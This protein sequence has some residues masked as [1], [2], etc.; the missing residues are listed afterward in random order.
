MKKKNRL[1]SVVLTAMMLL[2]MVSAGFTTFAAQPQDEPESP[3]PFDVSSLDEIKIYWARSKEWTT[4]ELDGPYGDVDENET[5]LTLRAGQTYELSKLLACVDDETDTTPNYTYA[6]EHYNPANLAVD[7]KENF[8][9]YSSMKIAYADEALK[10]RDTLAAEV[11]TAAA[12]AIWALYDAEKKFDG[13]KYDVK[14]VWD[15]GYRPA[16]VDLL[17]KLTFTDTTVTPSVTYEYDFQQSAYQ[18][19]TTAEF[20]GAYESGAS[21][22]AGDVVKGS[23]GSFYRYIGSGTTTNPPV[24]GSPEGAGAETYNSWEHLAVRIADAGSEPA[25]AYDVRYGIYHYQDEDRFKRWGNAANQGEWCTWLTHTEA[26]YY[27]LRDATTVRRFSGYFYLSDEDYQN[28]DLIYLALADGASLITGDDSMDVF[29]NGE[30]LYRASTN[31]NSEGRGDII[32]NGTNGETFSDA[33]NLLMKKNGYDYNNAPYSSPCN[34]PSGSENC[35]IAPIKYNGGSSWTPSD[36]AEAEKLYNENYAFA[37]YWHVHT[38]ES[39]FD[40]SS[41]LKPGANRIDIIAGDYDDGGGMSRLHLFTTGKTIKS[42][43]IDVEVN[44]YIDEDGSNNTKFDKQVSPV[45]DKNT[46]AVIT[47]AI[48]QPVNTPVY[49]EYIV[50][51]PNENTLYEVEV[52]DNRLGIKITPDGVYERENPGDP[53]SPWKSTPVD[54]SEYTVQTVDESGNTVDTTLEDLLSEIAGKTSD[55]TITRKTIRINFANT[56]FSDAGKYQTP[57]KA[58]GSTN[59]SNPATDRFEAANTTYVLMH[60]GVKNDWVVVDYG[61][62]VTLDVLTNDNYPEGSSPFLKALAWDSSDGNTDLEEAN[63]GNGTRPQGMTFTQVADSAAAAPAQTPVNGRYGQLFAASNDKNAVTYV[64]TKFIN[65]ADVFVYESEHKV[66]NVDQPYDRYATV[67]VVP[68]TSVY[69]EDN[70]SASTVGDAVEGAIIYGGNWSVV[71]DDGTGSAKPT[72]DGSQS[73]DNSSAGTDS[74]HYGYDDQY[75]DDLGLS[76]GSAHQV[77]G[78]EAN[79]PAWEEYKEDPANA[80][81][82]YRDYLLE[83]TAPL[84]EDFNDGSATVTFNFR[85][86]G[87]DIISYTDDSSGVMKCQ[88]TRQGDSAVVKNITV[89]NYYEVPGKTLYQI[90]VISV[91]NLDWG[92]YTVTLTVEGTRTFPSKGNVVVLDGIRIYNPLQPGSQTADD[93]YTQAE[94]HAVI[95]EIRDLLR[96]ETSDHNND[97]GGNRVK[98]L[99]VENYYVGSNDENAP[100]QYDDEGNLI[101]PNIGGVDLDRYNMDGPKN[102]IYVTSVGTGITF[103]Y[104][105]STTAIANSIPLTMQIEAKTLKGEASNMTVRCRFSAISDGETAAQ[106]PDGSWYK[107]K[108]VAVGSNTQMYYNLSDLFPKIPQSCV[109][110]IYKSGESVD[111]DIGTSKGSILSLSTIK[112]T[113]GTALGRNTDTFDPVETIA[114]GIT[115]N[116]SS[117]RIS[118]DGTATV[119]VLVTY[120]DGTTKTPK[121]A[122]VTLNVQEKEGS[123][124]LNSCVYDEK[125]G[126][127]TIAAGSITGE[128]GLVAASTDEAFLRTA[129]MAV[130]VVDNAEQ[131]NNIAGIAFLG[132]E[133]NAAFTLF[134]NGKPKNYI[135]VLVLENGE[136]ALPSN[137]GV[138]VNLALSGTQGV[139][140]ASAIGL[141]GI[142][143]VTPLAEGEGAVLT[144]SYNQFSAAL[145]FNVIPTPPLSPVSMNLAAP[146]GTELKIGEVTL[147]DASK[148]IVNYGAAGYDD[149]EARTFAEAAGD[150]TLVPSV[151]GI[152]AVINGQGIVEVTVDE[153]FDTASSGDISIAIQYGDL[154]L[155]TIK[156][157]ITYVA[158][159]AVSISPAQKQHLIAGGS[160]SF[161]AAVLPETATLRRVTWTGGA[162]GV[163]GFTVDENNPNTII[164]TAADSVALSEARQEVKFT[165]TAGNQTGAPSADATVYVYDITKAEPYNPAQGNYID[166]DFVIYGDAY[167]Y[168]EY[169]TSEVPGET[170]KGWIKVAN[171]S[172]GIVSVTITPPQSN[173]IFV[174]DELT[175]QAVVNAIGGADDSVTWSSDNQSVAT[176]DQTGKVTA[177]QAGEV[178][179][180]AASVYDST[181]TA[182]ITFTVAATIPVTGISISGADKIA[183]NRPDSTPPVDGTTTLVAEVSPAEATNK[184]VTWSSSNPAVATVDA[185][186][187]LVTG[188][189]AGQVTITAASVSNPEVSLDFAMEVVDF[190]GTVSVKP[191]ATAGSEYNLGGWLTT[192]AESAYLGTISSE[193]KICEPGTYY[194]AFMKGESWGGTLTFKDYEKIAEVTVSQFGE[195]AVRDIKWIKSGTIDY[196]GTQAVTTPPVVEPAGTTFAKLVKQADGSYTLAW[197]EGAAPDVAVTGLTL[198]PNTLSFTGKGSQKITCTVEPADATNRAVNWES[199]APSVVEVDQDGNV[200][201]VGVGT[202]VITVTSAADASIKATAQVTVTDAQITAIGLTNQ[203]LKKGGSVTLVPQYVPDNIIALPE[204]TWTS[205]TPSVAEVNQNGQV[206]AISKGTAT[207]TAQ[208]PNGVK[209]TAIITVEGASVTGVSVDINNVSFVKDGNV[210]TPAAQQVNAAVAPADAENKAVTWTSSNEAVARVDGGLI[211]PVGAGTA[212][213]TVTTV[214][215]GYTAKVTV[216]VTENAAEIPVTGVA[217]QK[218]GADVSGTTLNLNTGAAAQLQA[219]VSPAGA[220]NPAVSWSV[221]G[222]AATVSADGLVT[223]QAAGDAVVTVTTVDGSHTASVTIHVE[224]G[225]S[226]GLPVTITIANSTVNYNK[227][228]WFENG[229]TGSNSAV[230]GEREIT[231]PGTYYYGFTYLDTLATSLS[232]PALKFVVTADGQIT[233]TV[234]SFTPTWDGASYTLDYTD[235]STTHSF[236]ESN[237]TYTLVDAAGNEPMEA[238]SRALLVGNAPAILGVAENGKVTDISTAAAYSMMTDAGVRP[239]VV[240]SYGYSLTA[241]DGYTLLEDAVKSLVLENDRSSV[242]VI[243]INDAMTAN[244]SVRDLIPAMESLLNTIHTLSPEAKILLVGSRGAYVR[245]MQDAVQAAGLGAIVSFLE[246]TSSAITGTQ[247]VAEQEEMTQLIADKVAQILADDGDAD[248]SADAWTAITV[249]NVGDTVMYNGKKYECV[250]AHVARNNSYNPEQLPDYWKTVS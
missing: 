67:T 56:S 81:K 2:S 22:A 30:P 124:L 150:L 92:D 226:S 197:T 62:P 136:Y 106:A 1:I 58:T 221:T 187:G 228:A 104:G 220:T 161:T 145:Q 196:S 89:S 69:Y 213:I 27:N 78:V 100:P 235:G 86:T 32:I 234:G 240:A 179:I 168:C 43:Q 153:D 135:P 109:F 204:I 93:Y 83:K 120:S 24:L 151:A 206:T 137:L 25:E 116:R 167:Y 229:Q 181:K 143:T 33:A 117:M 134:N 250:V 39:T 219:V 171:V 130:E 80:G 23:D 209:G 190:A 217:I 29:V 218:D 127:V 68:A 15:G 178:T 96:N 132:Q 203:T 154:V 237:G 131:L 8:Y 84:K 107:E 148:S 51:N 9:K 19:V 121:E 76:F 94:K 97:I 119:G 142:V 115:F 60:T 63:K 158:P 77:G 169:W 162:A 20:R 49:Y 215:G 207:I 183:V 144:A 42:G 223:A 85:G 13:V 14:Y 192:T 6:T 246:D 5:V 147:I 247:A 180:T 38:S 17:T 73:N 230:H 174:G 11:G 214:D 57:V 21:Y 18:S 99:G 199:S 47:E 48:S 152:H 4:G 224:G 74:D 88:V 243:S 40:I 244:D 239:T 129:E 133:N 122:G 35:V 236:T 222:T 191:V 45:F 101:P 105:P 188:I 200:T 156:A 59:Q 10:S 194:Y 12:D 212:E 34:E 185:Q 52:V 61:L 225:S 157:K 208:A 118:K 65:D 202:A 173:T 164:V 128:T 91:K 216:T 55:G 186:T 248:T 3:V 37:A 160:T 112:V 113:E 108:T 82:T 54:P 166:G 102:E 140:E 172:A 110:E 141:G 28:R 90:P 66:A 155:E 210:F 53:D 139:V 184:A 201:V 114:T 249:Y 79:L 195:V 189:S 170:A 163:A 75:K 177:L 242:V 211:T 111:P 233:C 103:K 46:S 149:T 70:F 87:F 125:T 175:L 165:A 245:Y 176:V 16:G 26:D 7:T 193:L 159:N 31:D 238:N 205:D 95:Y 198:N 71:T 72:T 50:S 126:V 44:A 232:G 241:K 41:H 138:T 64:P 98:L 182:F 123:S 146:S 36:P 227:G 231:T